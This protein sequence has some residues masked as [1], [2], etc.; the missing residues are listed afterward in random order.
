MDLDDF[1][2]A[3][4]AAAKENGLFCDPEKTQI[5]MVYQSRPDLPD[6][7][8]QTAPEQVVHGVSLA[9]IQGLSAAKQKKTIAE[10]SKHVLD[11]H[12]RIAGR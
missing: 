5:Q 10:F 3:M 6:D 7:T 4:T 9:F 11:H 8:P 2:A 1:I 12:K